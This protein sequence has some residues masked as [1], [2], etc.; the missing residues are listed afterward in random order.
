MIAH[1]SSKEAA[2]SFRFMQLSYKE[3]QNSVVPAVALTAI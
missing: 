2:E 1:I 3:Q